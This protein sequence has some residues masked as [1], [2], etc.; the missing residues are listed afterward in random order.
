MYLFADNK[1]YKAEAAA[2]RTLARTSV[3]TS[4]IHR[5]PPK[6]GFDTSI[7]GTRLDFMLFNLPP[8][9]EYSRMTLKNPINKP[10]LKENGHRKTQQFLL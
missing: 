4:Q 5:V 8:A 7:T 6:K 9:C 2:R 3:R 10:V 1:R